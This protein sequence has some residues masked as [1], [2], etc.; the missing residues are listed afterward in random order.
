MQYARYSGLLNKACPQDK[1]FYQGLKF[2]FGWVFPRPSNQEER[3]YQLKPTLA[4]LSHLKRKGHNEE[5]LEVLNPKTQAHYTFRANHRITECF[6]SPYILTIA[7]LTIYHSF[8][9][10]VHYIW[11]PRKN[12]KTY[13]KANTQVTQNSSHQNSAQVWQGCWN[14]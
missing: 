3:K 10:S 12:Y 14:S 5:Q 13:L 7:S 6:P 2:L 1:L 9:C 11:L 8:F 4:I